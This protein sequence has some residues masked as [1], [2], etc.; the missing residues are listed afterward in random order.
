MNQDVLVFPIE[1][2]DFPISHVIVFK[3]GRYQ[4]IPLLKLLFNTPIPPKKR[5]I[6]KKHR[7]PFIFYFWGG[8]LYNFLLVTSDP[9]H[10]FPGKDGFKRASTARMQLAHQRHGGRKN[11]RTARRLP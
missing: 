3:G 1:N 2:E 11:G 4:K 10:Y 7:I 8:K 6:T 5:N 9:E